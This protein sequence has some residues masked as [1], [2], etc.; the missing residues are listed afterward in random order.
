MP[1]RCDSCNSFHS[2]SKKSDPMAEVLC[3]TKLSTNLH[4]HN[5]SISVYPN[6]NQLDSTRF[7]TKRNQFQSL[8]T[9][10]LSL[11]TTRR[12][13]VDGTIPAR[14][15]H[16]PERLWNP[17]A[18]GQHFHQ[19]SLELKKRGARLP[20]LPTLRLQLAL[21]TQNSRSLHRA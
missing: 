13:E 19:I 18:R 7:I 14:F 17:S 8:P 3:T 4:S 6:V 11:Q 21:P 10:R 15:R 5:P 2:W 12:N 9:A 20:K 16:K 1:L